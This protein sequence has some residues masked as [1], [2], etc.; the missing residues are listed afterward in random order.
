MFPPNRAFIGMR[1]HEPVLREYSRTWRKQQVKIEDIRFGIEIET[2][3]R[4]RGTVAAAIQSVVG[5][6]ARHVGTPS[7]YDPW[8]VI[9]AKGRTWKVVA[10]SSLTSVPAHLRAE[11]VSPILGYEDIPEFQ[12]VV[13]A[14]RGCGATTDECTGIHVHVSHP[15]VTARALANLAKLIYKQQDIIYAA[16]GVTQQRMARYCKPLDPAFI[17]RITK[18]PPRDLRQLNT[19]WYGRYIQN[20]QRYDSSRYSILNLNGF[21]VRQALEMRAYS[22]SL[23]AGRVKAVILFSMALLA[24]AMSCRGASARKRTYDPASAK[25]D[26][27]VFLISALKMNGP[28]FKTARMHLLRLMPGDAAWKHGRPSTKAKKSAGETAQAG[29]GVCC[30]AN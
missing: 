22:G 21:F 2:V 28:E 11:V 16:L 10:D 3:K 18:N 9:D 25:Y 5:G 7:V 14:I 17:E 15:D 27:R 13:R 20:P 26:M 29:S 4:D 12:D 6:E 23:H 30:G 8:E 19:Q 24:R 1:E